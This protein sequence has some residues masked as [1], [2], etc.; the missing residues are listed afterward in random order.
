MAP[1]VE[2]DAGEGAAGHADCCGDD[3]DDGSVDALARRGAHLLRAF[4]E[5][6]ST[7]LQR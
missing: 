2:V 3:G 5:A 4:V 6:L 1:G 7:P